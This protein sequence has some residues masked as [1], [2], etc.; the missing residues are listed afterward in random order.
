M[1]RQADEFLTNTS[2]HRWWVKD[3]EQ[4]DLKSSELMTPKFYPRQLTR[5]SSMILP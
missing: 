5:T 2:R 4:E 3:T 1:L